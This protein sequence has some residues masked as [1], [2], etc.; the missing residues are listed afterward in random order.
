MLTIQDPSGQY[1]HFAF[2]DRDKRDEFFDACTNL[3]AGRAWNKTAEQQAADDAE[4]AAAALVLEN[5]RL[6]AER[7]AQADEDRAPAPEPQMQSEFMPAFQ[8]PPTTNAEVRALRA[9]SGNPMHTASLLDIGSK[10]FRDFY[11]VLKA[12]PNDPH[13]TAERIEDEVRAESFRLWALCLVRM[14]TANQIKNVSSELKRRFFDTSSSTGP[15]SATAIA[16]QFGLSEMVS[17]YEGSDKP[18]LSTPPGPATLLGL[19]AGQRQA[20]RRTLQE[21]C[22]RFTLSG[23]PEFRLA[24]DADVPSPSGWQQVDRI[25]QTYAQMM[26]VYLTNVGDPEEVEPG[27]GLFD[28][29]ESGEC[30][31][32]SDDT[33]QNR[34]LELVNSFQDK[35]S[36]TAMYTDHGALKSVLHKPTAEVLKDISKMQKPS[37]AMVCKFGAKWAALPTSQNS[38]GIVAVA[39]GRQLS[40]Q[41]HGLCGDVFGDIKETL[42]PLCQEFYTAVSKVKFKLDV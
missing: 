5:E 1:G 25:I 16:S 41:L 13:M 14:Q 6:E 26:Q 22:D 38:D 23:L 11:D 27:F 35:V 42:I 20:Q 24:T 31:W 34:L 2:Q 10:V 36:P 33:F 29:D 7:M 37:L 28:R 9:G 3:A 8:R 30:I 40:N 18:E 4:I 32:N 19:H 15:F 21:I 17:A 39:M 12:N